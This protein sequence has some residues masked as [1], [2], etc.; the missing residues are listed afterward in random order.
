M[1]QYWFEEA[2][3]ND[4]LR[5]EG[6]LG[7]FNLRNTQANNVIFLATGTGIAPVKAMLEYLS[8]SPERAVGKQLHVYWGGR[9]E[10][11]IY[12]QPIFE[13]LIIKFTPVL[14]RADSNYSGR[15]GYVQQA[16]LE[17]QVDL[18]DAVVY[19]CGSDSMIC[20]ARDQL[21]AAGLAAKN[22]YSDAFLSSTNQEK[23]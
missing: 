1:S 14:S 11:D 9:K 16:L 8:K 12:W 21:T 4:L 18:R 10:K 23:R 13:N 5:L 17:D 6:P 2:Q 19:A 15:T 20:S 22:F 3:S 7:T